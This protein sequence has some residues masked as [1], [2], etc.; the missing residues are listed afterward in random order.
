MRGSEGRA[1]EYVVALEGL[2]EAPEGL[3]YELWAM[4]GEEEAALL[5]VLET[6]VC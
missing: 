2:P 4:A 1:S 6:E 5:G 3:R